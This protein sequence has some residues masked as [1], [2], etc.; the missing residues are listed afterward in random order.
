M[1]P[2]APKNNRGG[3]AKPVENAVRKYVM[4]AQ[5]DVYAITDPYF[6]GLRSADPTMEKIW[7]PSA[8]YKLVYDLTA[9]KSWAYW[10]ENKND[11]KLTEVISYQTLV[12]RTGIHFLPELD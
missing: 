2:Q 12:E 3:W 10:V 8:L 7:V 6:A 5:G 11:A 9:G 1:V 4:R